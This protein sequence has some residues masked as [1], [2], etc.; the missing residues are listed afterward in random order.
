MARRSRR[1]SARRPAV[2]A[3]PGRTGEEVEGA[4]TSDAINLADE[5][6][7]E[8]HFAVNPAAALASKQYEFE[9]YDQTNGSAIGTG[10]AA[11]TIAAQI[12]PPSVV[13]NTADGYDFGSDTIP[14]LD[15]TGTDPDGE[16]VRYQ[17]HIGIR[18]DSYSE[19]NWDTIAIIDASD[20]LEAAQS[21]NG[22]G[23]ALSGCR[24]YLRRYGSPTRNVTAKLYAITGTHGTDAKP[25]GA[26][27]A[28][29]DP[30]NIESIGTTIEL[31]HFNSYSVYNYTRYEILHLGRLQRGGC[32]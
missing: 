7:T 22:S 2:P 30:V 4:A 28:T 5:Y 31:V 9:L 27:L 17:V 16:D 18:G 11:I 13:L 20:T 1:S 25:T 24:F 26:A 21:F 8:V 15:F 32:E 10:A 29:S 6:Y 23:G 3:R 12:G 14:T 19:T